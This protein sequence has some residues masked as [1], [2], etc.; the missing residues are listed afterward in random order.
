MFFSVDPGSIHL[1]DQL[2]AAFLRLVIGIRAYFQHLS[3]SGASGVIEQVTRDNVVLSAFTNVLFTKK[4]EEK[5]KAA[6][7][8][9]LGCVL[10]CV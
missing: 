1:Y 3:P 4:A 5:I 6:R 9:V 10:L 8:L 7:L 2:P